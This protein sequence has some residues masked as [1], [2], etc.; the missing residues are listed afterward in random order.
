MPR[1]IDLADEAQCGLA[2]C[3]EA[4]G[5]HGFDPMDEESLMHGAAWL[6]RLGNNTGFLGDLLVENLTHRHRE[7]ADKQS[8]GPQ[9][10][11]LSEHRGGCFLR[12]NIWPGAEDHLLVASGR[13]P[14]LYDMPHDHNFHFLTLGYFGPGY[15]SDYFEYD[16]SEVSGWQGEPVRL[17]ALGRQQLD[18]GKLMLYRAHHD[19]HRQLPAESL[20]VSVNIM[21]ANPALGWLDQYR[22]DVEGGKLGAIISHGSTDVFLR[23][24]VA[25][26]GEESLD[27]AETFAACHPSD[28]MRLTASDA[29]ASRLTDI[30]ERDAF[31][32]RAE[33]SGSRMVAA[34]AKARRAALA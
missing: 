15:Q 28:R 2:E 9:S 23:V 27:L 31:W 25:L 10:I 1:V 30:A 13:S 17:K 29:L 19:V 11:V 3:A 21:H 8:Y 16:Y 33:Q 6:R 18:P 32:A 7:D 12:A 34:E 4:L 26:G 14:F 24:A 5:S 22:F 20:S